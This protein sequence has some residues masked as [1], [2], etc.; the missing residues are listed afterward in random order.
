MFQ[1]EHQVARPVIQ[2][3]LGPTGTANVHT[4]HD[5]FPGAGVFGQAGGAPWA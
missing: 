2:P 5:P 1:S 3:R 4:L